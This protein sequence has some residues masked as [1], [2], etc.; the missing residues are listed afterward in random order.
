MLEFSDLSEW[1]DA[2]SELNVEEFIQQ[3]LRAHEDTFALTF[4]Q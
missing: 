3:C 1:F 2:P 4:N